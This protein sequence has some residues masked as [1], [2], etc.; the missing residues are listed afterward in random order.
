M[1]INANRARAITIRSGCGETIAGEDELQFPMVR[2]NAYHP[3]EI[4]MASACNTGSE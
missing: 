4:E 1:R 2:L 3:V